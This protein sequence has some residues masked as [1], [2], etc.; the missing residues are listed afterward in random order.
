MKMIF[1]LYE[2]K[3]AMCRAAQPAVC[4]SVLL[5]LVVEVLITVHDYNGSSLVWAVRSTLSAINSWHVSLE[6]LLLPEVLL[7]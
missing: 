5:F 1:E 6:A 2:R 4:S 7:A 3:P